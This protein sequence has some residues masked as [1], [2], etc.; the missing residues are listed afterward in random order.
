[1]GMQYSF[2]AVDTVVFSQCVQRK[3]GIRAFLSYC[4]A[5]YGLGRKSSAAYGL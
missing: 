3:T 1:M 4:S 2:K 5:T